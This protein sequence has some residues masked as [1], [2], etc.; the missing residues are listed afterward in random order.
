[1]CAEPWTKEGELAVSVKS[2]NH[3]GLDLHIQT[4]P[5]VEP[6]EGMI[7]AMVK[8]AVVRGHVEV[9]VSVPK[10]VAAGSVSVNRDL[11]RDYLRLYHTEAQTPTASMRS[12]I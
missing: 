1:M 4:P 11:L 5:A 8:E 7:R 2:V 3:R 6:Y 10:G 12:L 9:R